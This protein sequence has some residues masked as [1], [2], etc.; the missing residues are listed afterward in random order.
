MVPHAEITIIGLGAAGLILLKEIL[1]DS[2][3]QNKKIFLID[4]G[5]RQEKNWAYWA[6]S[7]NSFSHLS[8]KTWENIGFRGPAL[9]EQN[10]FIKPYHYQLISS[11][12]IFDY[13]FN[14][15]IPSHK[16]IKIIK[17][18]VKNCQINSSGNHEIIL[19][20]GE[21]LSSTIIGDSRIDLNN[22]QGKIELKQHFYGKYIKIKEPKFNE[23]KAILM[24]FNFPSI[25]NTVGFGYILPFNSHEAFVEIT[26]FDEN[27]LTEKEYNKI[28]DQY[29][30]INLN[31]QKYET[32]QVEMGCIPMSN[33]YFNQEITNNYFKIGTAAGMVKNSTGYAFT[34]M[35]ED[36]KIIVKSKFSKRR[37]LNE[38]K[39]RFKIYDSILLNIIHK[40]PNRVK[41]V[42]NKLFRNNPG[43]RI[44]KFLDE[45]TN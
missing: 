32:S 12:S 14:T 9:E 26:F 28:W 40:E 22:G 2:E 13:M 38:S 16:N 17:G 24:D 37:I 3:F 19:E 1:N 42:M 43:K 4:S 36:S 7:S 35:I 10:H 44:L 29:W 41:D 8:I 18:R 39:L 5:E 31:G 21:K 45:K 25:Q 34:R 11:K 33:R 27:P 6:H 23:K 20:N 30:H 15:V